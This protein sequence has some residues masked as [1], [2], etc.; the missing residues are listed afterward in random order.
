A[1]PVADISPADLDAARAAV[2]EL[3]VR[4]GP[5]YVAQYGWAAHELGDKS[6][7]GLHLIEGHLDMTR[8]RPYAGMANHAVH[9]GARALSFDLGSAP[10][11][12]WPPI[13]ASDQGL[14]D[15]G[16]NACLALLWASAALLS[17]QGSV[18][19]I[20]NLRAPVDGDRLGHG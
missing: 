20:A 9:A 11:E 2:A 14:T 7:V 18:Q 4:F 16:Q 19:S 8:W 17:H 12:H 6:R 5:E 13:G 15:P 10:R 1:E 3:K